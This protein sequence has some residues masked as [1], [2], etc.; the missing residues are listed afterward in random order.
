[1]ADTSATEAAAA[2]AWKRYPFTIGDDPELSFPTAEGDQGAESNTYYVA[3]RL[4]GRSTGRRWAFF[5]IFTFNDVRFMPGL[6]GEGVVPTATRWRYPQ[7]PASLPARIPVARLRQFEPVG[8][9]EGWT[10]FQKIFVT[11]PGLRQSEIVALVGPSG[12]GKSTALRLLAGLEPPTTWAD[13]FPNPRAIR[14]RQSRRS[15]RFTG[16]NIGNLRFFFNDKISL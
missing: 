1:M 2:S 11:L 15:K 14:L 10:T 13:Y 4:T 16:L 7:A 5:V 3:G 12:C 9:G 8:L 6:R